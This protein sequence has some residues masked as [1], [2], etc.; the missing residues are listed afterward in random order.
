MNL[1]LGFQLQLSEQIGAINLWRI[2]WIQLTATPT[3]LKE[4]GVRVCKLDVTHEYVCVLR[5]WLA[6]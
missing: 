3:S 4:C 2:L 6:L 5:V 1:F